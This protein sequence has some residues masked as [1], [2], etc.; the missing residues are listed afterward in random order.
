[1]KVGRNTKGGGKGV[2]VVFALRALGVLPS[3]WGIIKKARWDNE[4]INKEL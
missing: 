1:M 3:P 2:R 4:D